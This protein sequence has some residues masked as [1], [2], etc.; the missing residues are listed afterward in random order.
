MDEWM[1]RG[2]FSYN[3][4]SVSLKKEGNSN[5]FCNIDEFLGHYTK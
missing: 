1:N 2:L 4:I 3:G 5:T